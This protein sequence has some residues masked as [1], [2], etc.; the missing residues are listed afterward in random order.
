ME[1][2]VKATAEQ[3]TPQDRGGPG[4]ARSAPWHWALVI[5]GSAAVVAT[6]LAAGPATGTTVAARGAV[7]ALPAAAAPDPAK[8]EL[9]LDCGPF[10]VKISVSFAADLGDGRPG[11]V[12]AAHCAAETGTPPDA[13]YLLGPGDGGRP[14]VLATLVAERENLTVSRLGL[15]SDGVITGHAQGYSSDDVPRFSPDIS[16]DLTW[17][18][19]GGGWDR[20]Q[21]AAPLAQA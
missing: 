3:Q 21:T 5:A 6:A 10:P 9:P 11:T 17:T 4:H 13:V 14:V 15:R 8:A 12:A 19:K 16:L 1:T 18:R 20:A 2:A 7:K